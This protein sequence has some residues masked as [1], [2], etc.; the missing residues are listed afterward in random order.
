VITTQP[1]LLVGDNNMVFG[2]SMIFELLIKLLT[3]VPEGYSL[4]LHPIA[5]AGWVGLFVTAINLFPIGQL[6]GG[7]IAYVF[8][9]KR[10]RYI[11]YL[12]F[13]IL[14]FL[15]LEVSPGWMF[16]IFML[17]FMGIRHPNVR[18]MQAGVRLDKMRIRQGIMSVVM[19]VICF[20]P[21][22]LKVTADIM[23]Q[24]VTTPP[25]KQQD[26]QNFHNIFY[27]PNAESQS[28]GKYK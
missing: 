11:A 7:H 9:G 4:V 27:S 12:F 1:G 19:F 18:M 17:F 20:I 2:T 10:Q 25:V 3:T 15:A 14:I 8:L 5:F 24:P 26:F 22:P 6:D 23:P 13:G 16:W 28:I 21:E